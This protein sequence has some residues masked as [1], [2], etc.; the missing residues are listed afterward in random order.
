MSD[1]IEIT[2]L[3][4]SEISVHVKGV[5]GPACRDLTKFLES[6]G[7]VISTEDTDEFHEMETEFLSRKEK[8]DIERN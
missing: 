1:E 5:K 8:G 3:P 6:L 4:N 2:I 7:E